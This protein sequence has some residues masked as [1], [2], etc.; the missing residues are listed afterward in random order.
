MMFK[1]YTKPNCPYCKQVVDFLTSQ[2]VQFG[3]EDPG[4]NPIVLSGLQTYLGSIAIQYPVIV[5]F[6][7]PGAIIVGANLAE[8]SRIIAAARGAGA[9]PSDALADGGQAAQV[10]ANGQAAISSRNGGTRTYY[11]PR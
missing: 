4:F 11:F 1:V 10:P 7:H 3:A 6:S 5:S 2:K 8:L 9:I